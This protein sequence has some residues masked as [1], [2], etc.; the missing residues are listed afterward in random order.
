MLPAVVSRIKI[1]AGLDISERRMPQDGGITIAM[2]GR[3]VD[4][5]VSTMPGKH[6]EKVVLRII[7]TRNA[8]TGLDQLGLDPTLLDRLRNIL[9]QPN[10]VFLVTGPTGSGKSTTL[11]AAL[12]EI[13]SDKVNISTVENPVEYSV[14]GINQFQTHDKAGFTFASALRALL[15]QDPDIIMV[16][17]VRD[18]ETAKIATQAALTGHLVLSTLHT[19]DAPSAITRLVN[20][21]VEPYLIA[22]CIRGVLAQRLVRKIC[23]SC[24]E[25]ITPDAAQQRLV[26]QITDEGG[27]RIEKLF[28]GSGCNRCRN[29]GYA[30]RLGLYELYMPDD[31]ALDAISRGATLQE[32]RKLARASE[33]YT[34][35]RQDAVAKIN[36]GLTT[37]DELIKATAA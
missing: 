23:S 14:E 27:G 9:H 17:E 1:M 37:L 29:T 31:E 26:E 24:A 34:T 28:A 25:E 18:A 10:G 7:D 30:G 12:N 8:M 2:K 15:R 22:A 33:S 11:Y 16:G 6:G 20:I 3:Q 32:V 36:R 19:N 5:R 21:G 13:N 4:L 35:L